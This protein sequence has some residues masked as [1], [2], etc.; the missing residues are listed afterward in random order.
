V[1][2]DAPIVNETLEEEVDAVIEDLTVT[3]EETVEAVAEETPT[4]VSPE[5]VV[6]TEDAK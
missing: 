1:S 4:E 5:E 2:E 3:E 6:T